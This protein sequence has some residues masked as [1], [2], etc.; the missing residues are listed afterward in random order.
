MLVRKIVITFEGG[1]LLEEVMD[2]CVCLSVCMC[3][4]MCVLLVDTMQAIAACSCCNAS[5]PPQWDIF[6]NTVSHS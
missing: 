2:V 3:V 6:P 1:V 5:P 4:F